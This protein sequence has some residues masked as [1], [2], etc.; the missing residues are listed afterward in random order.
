MQAQEWRRRAWHWHPIPVGRYGEVGEEAS[1][2][3][4]QGRAGGDPNPIAGGRK[5]PVAAERAAAVEAEG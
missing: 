2:L 4:G 5:P 1:R 3:E